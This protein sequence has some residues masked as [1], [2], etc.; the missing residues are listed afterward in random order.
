MLK[1]KENTERKEVINMWTSMREHCLF[2]LFLH[3]F[4][5]LNLGIVQSSSISIMYQ[6]LSNV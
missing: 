5:L 6:L 4:H 2:H 1:R 3:I